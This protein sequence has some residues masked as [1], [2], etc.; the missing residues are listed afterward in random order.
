MKFSTKYWILVLNF[1]ADS[2]YQTK[3][4]LCE[5]FTVPGL[6]TDSIDKQLR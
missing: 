5:Q 2:W 3:P 6:D 1:Y 4:D